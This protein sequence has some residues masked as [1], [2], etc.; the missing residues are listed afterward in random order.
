MIDKAL[1]MLGAVCFG[2]A[3]IS[4]LFWYDWRV[5]LGVLFIM[6]GWDFARKVIK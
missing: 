4:L 6:W 3:G 1:Y 2:V 5:L